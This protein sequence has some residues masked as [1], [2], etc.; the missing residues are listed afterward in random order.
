M[1]PCS[2]PCDALRTMYAMNP[3]LRIARRC[4]S[5]RGHM[6]LTDAIGPKRPNSRARIWGIGSPDER[7]G[8]MRCSGR[9]GEEGA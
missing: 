5:V 1:Q 2:P 7:C 3:Q 9:R 6:I 4:S 8:V